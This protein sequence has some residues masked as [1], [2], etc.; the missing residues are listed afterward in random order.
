MIFLV[1]KISLSKH[2][3]YQAYGGWLCVC[4]YIVNNIEKNLQEGSGCFPL[5]YTGTQSCMALCSCSWGYFFIIFI[6]WF[7]TNSVQSF[8][9]IIIIYARSNFV[10]YHRECTSIYNPLSY[11]LRK[12]K[13]VCKIL[14]LYIIPIV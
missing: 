10:Y 8:Q 12:R 14:F 13:D 1:I 9:Q 6:T 11:P 5:N 7:Q 3:Y 2:Y 4:L